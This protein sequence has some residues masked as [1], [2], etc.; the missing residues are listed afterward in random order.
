[1]LYFQLLTLLMVFVIVA[2]MPRDRLNQ[3]E[4]II[5]ETK[6]AF[7]SRPPAYSGELHISRTL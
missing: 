6:S 5:H 4:N 3:L 7:T 2:G 1:M